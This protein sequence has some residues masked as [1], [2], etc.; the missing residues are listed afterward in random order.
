M[1]RLSALKDEVVSLIGAPCM[2]QRDRTGRALFF[3]DYVRRGIDGADK[4]LSDAG[5]T[6]EQKDGCAH[7]GLTKEKGEQFLL[8]L[9]EHPL[10]PTDESGALPLSACRMLLRHESRAGAPAPGTLHRALL[11]WDAEQTNELA[12][13][14]QT[15]LALA[16]RNKA[17]VPVL[18][19]RLLCD[20]L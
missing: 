13:M 16:L 18:L 14:L 20:L 10:P 3:S 6:A 17:P 1:K 5:F 8:S 11:L 19:A 2:V 15:E 7:I 9:P 4:R 12:L